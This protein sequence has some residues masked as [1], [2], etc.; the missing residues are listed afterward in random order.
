M[1]REKASMR[2]RERRVFVHEIESKIALKIACLKGALGN[3]YN[4]MVAKA[5]N[6]KLHE[7][8]KFLL[9][10]DFV[11]STLR[12][13][14]CAI[15]LMQATSGCVRVDGKGNSVS[16]ASSLNSLNK[17]AYLENGQ[18]IPARTP[19]VGLSPCRE[20]CLV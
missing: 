12:S 17:K 4:A 2:G 15:S 10:Q 8:R 6:R 9:T 20:P 5:V 13:S 1:V 7:H 16:A 19:S 3:S 11:T 14:L 18:K